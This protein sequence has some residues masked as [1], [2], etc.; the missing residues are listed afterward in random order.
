MY[1]ITV[2]SQ[3]RTAMDRDIFSH[4]EIRRSN[5]FYETCR[6]LRIFESILEKNLCLHELAE[7]NQYNEINIENTAQLENP[8]PFTFD[9]Y[10]AAHVAL[11]IN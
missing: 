1:I 10:R 7:S 3:Q 4:S 2:Q 6:F 8:F 9:F 5:L 11:I